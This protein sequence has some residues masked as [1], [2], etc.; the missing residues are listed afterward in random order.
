MLIV[1][2]LEARADLVV[3]VV[4]FVSDGDCVQALQKAMNVDGFDP[5]LAGIWYRRFDPF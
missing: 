4:G 2:E 1:D 3:G 5:N